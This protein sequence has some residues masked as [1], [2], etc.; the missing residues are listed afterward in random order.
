MLP[1]PEKVVGSHFDIVSILLCIRLVIDAAI[2]MR[3]ASRVCAQ[4]SLILGLPSLGESSH[5]TVQNLMLRIGV[6]LIEHHAGF[7]PNQI[8]II[9]HTQAAGTTQCLIVVGVDAAV[10]LQ[11][12]RPLEH[13]DL[14]TLAILPVNESNGAIVH[15]QLAELSQDKGLPLAILS[16]RGSELKKGVELLQGDHPDVISLTDIVHLVS[17]QIQKLLEQDERWDL[18]RQANGKY[19]WYRSVACRADVPTALYTLPPRLLAVR[20]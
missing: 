12:N 19:G 15:K 8:W 14:E 2:S 18:C 4:L 3:S 6:Y 7:N 10:Y 20:R 9:D 16:D 11:C 5:T 1:A 13:R 17:R